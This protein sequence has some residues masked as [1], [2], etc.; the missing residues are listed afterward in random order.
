MN[1]WP[2]MITK[3]RSRGMS[4]SAIA[5]KINETRPR[6]IDWKQVKRWADGVE[7]AH[8]DGERIIALVADPSE[9]CGSSHSQE[10]ASP[11]LSC[12]RL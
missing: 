6:D 9:P 3:L 4:Y 5:A 8:S 1:D 11:G 10:S 7:P 12:E 2:M